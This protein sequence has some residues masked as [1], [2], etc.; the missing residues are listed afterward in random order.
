MPH[1]QLPA[2]RRDYQC[3]CGRPVFLRNT[4]CLTCGSQLGFET[5]RLTM[6]AMVPGPLPA[7]WRVAGETTGLT[8][9]F[10]VNRQSASACNWLVV[11][12]EPYALLG[13]LE[14]RCLACRLN[15]KM[16]DVTRPVN[17]Y[18]WRELEI[19]K[20]RLLSQLLALHLPVEVRSG[21]VKGMAFDML[22]QLPEGPP[23][24]TGHCDGVITLDVAEADDVQRETA[25]AAMGE[26]Y[27]TLLGH[28]RHEIGHYYWDRL[29]Y[30]DPERLAQFRALFGDER[31]DYSKA[32][33][34]HYRNSPRRDWKGIFLSSYASAHPWED[35]AETWAHYLHI[36]DT[37]DTA[38]SFGIDVDAAPTDSEPIDSKY[39]WQKDLPGSQSFLNLLN[40]WVKLTQVM[41][42]LSRSMGQP[43]TYPFVTPFRAVAKLHFIHQTILSHREKTKNIKKS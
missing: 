3:Q 31:A 29:V 34:K 28:F 17:Q 1:L 6:V 12:T 38:V 15:R 23:V 35:W 18:R 2:A 42:E 9:R 43:D 16:F 37:V 14:T 19:A 30:Q 4:Q 21:S 36:T 25:R 5:S 33:R 7:L 22:E 20:R 27:R 32:L 10:C 24:V 11:S 8:Y 41:N 26:P 13:K 39:L 40:A